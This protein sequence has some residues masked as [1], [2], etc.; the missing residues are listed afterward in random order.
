VKQYMEP[1]RELGKKKGGGRE[2]TIE[3]VWSDGCLDIEVLKPNAWADKERP[4]GAEW[5]EME[6]LKGHQRTH[7][8]R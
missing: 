6:F 3:I 4:Q 1:L 8:A 5:T 2:D 7:S